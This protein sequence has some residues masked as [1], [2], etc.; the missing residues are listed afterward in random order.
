[1]ELHLHP[2]GGVFMELTSREWWG[3]IHGMV[4]GAAFLIAFAGGL[5]GFYS[6]RPGLL[7]EAGIAERTKRL[8]I[9]TWVMA[10]AAWLTV[11]TGTWIVYP[12]YRAEPTKL[13]IPTDVQSEAL[14]DFPRYWLRG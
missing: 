1:M 9:G 5:A 14:K 10:A 2:K 7:T 12:W 8:K 13:G 3:I 6:L 4:L 11:F